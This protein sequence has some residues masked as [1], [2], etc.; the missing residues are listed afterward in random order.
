[1]H[2]QKKERDKPERKLQYKKPK[3]TL[4][5]KIKNLTLGGSPGL[6]ES[7]QAGTFFPPGTP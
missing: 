2:Q 5:G 7:S 3:L 4:F 1:M 6:G